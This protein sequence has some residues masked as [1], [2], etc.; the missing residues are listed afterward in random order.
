MEDSKQLELAATHIDELLNL[1]R[2]IWLLGA[3]ISKDAG[4]PLMYDLT[5]RVEALLVSQDSELGNIDTVRSAL[6]YEKIGS[7]LPDSAHVE[8]VLSQLGDLICLAERKKKKTVILDGE[9]ITADEL[10]EAHHHIQLAIRYT[11]EYGYIPATKDQAERVGC[12]DTPIVDRQNHDVF[13]KSLFQD[14]R[15]GLDQNPP[16]HFVTTNYDTLLE[17]A[18]AHA[19]IGY[20]DGFAGGATGFW[21]PRNRHDWLEH[22]ARLRRHTASLCKLHGSIDWVTDEADVVMR[23]RSTMIDTAATRGQ[24]LL[25]YPQATKYQVTQRDPFASLFSE[26][27]R[28]LVSSN[29]TILTICGYSFGDDHVNEEIERAL[30]TGPSTLTVLA[31]CCQTTDN[32]GNL[33]ENEG[34]PGV[35]VKWLREPSCA[36]RIVVLGSHGFYHESLQNRIPSEPSRDWWTFSGISKVLSQ[37]PEAVI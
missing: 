21:D 26:F 23:V 31:L 8:H 36:N 11:V 3:G 4:V 27:R 19:H 10:R 28:L 1:P 32:D 14:R 12:P 18:L 22:A 37:G 20:I 25:I 29:P 17:D 13:V 35:I 7:E 16:V 6:L 15:A 30:R 5:G 2:Q 24:R 33:G 34:L 9:T